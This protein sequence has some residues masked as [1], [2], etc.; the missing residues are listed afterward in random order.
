M[1]R[2]RIPSAT[3]GEYSKAIVFRPGLTG[4]SAFA[5]LDNVCC[6]PIKVPSRRYRQLSSLCSS[7]NVSPNSGSL[8]N[9][10]WC[11]NAINRIFTSTSLSRPDDLYLP[12]GNLV[13][14]CAGFHSHSTCLRGIFRDPSDQRGSPLAKLLESLKSKT[15]SRLVK[16]F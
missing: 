3:P 8:R 16:F 11:H 1:L 15:R 6:R 13:R 9:R 12:W 4:E 2:V 5:R 7:S 10:L 14:R